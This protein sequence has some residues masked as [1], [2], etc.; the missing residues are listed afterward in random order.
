MIPRLAIL[1]LPFFLLTG[2]AD[3][4]PTKATHPDARSLFNDFTISAAAANQCS[5]PSQD[6][7]NHFNANYRLVAMATSKEL[8]KQHPDMNQKQ[9]AE[10]MK[11]QSAVLSKKVSDAVKEKGCKDPA[12]AGLVQRFDLQAKWDPRK[13]V[14][15]TAQKDK[16]KT[17]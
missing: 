10:A 3:A 13:Q 6:T 11:K 16:A 7:I 15:N 9:I 8:A 1:F 17:K 2:T 12:V 4:A 5:K 14:Q